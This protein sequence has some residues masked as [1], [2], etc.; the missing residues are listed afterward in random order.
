MTRVVLL[1]PY[2]LA[3]Y[4]GVQEQALAMSRE[5]VRRGYDVELVAP[6]AHGEVAARTPARLRDAGASVSIP[7]NGSRAAL[8]LAPTAS[9]RARRAV[10]TD[11]GTVVHL[12]EPFAPVVGWSTLL[13]HRTP[14]VGTLHRAGEGPA[15]RWTRPIL[16]RLARGLDVIAAVS[17]AAARTMGGAA[18]LHPEI[19]FNGFETDRYREVARVVSPTPTILVVGRLEE[20]KGTRVA[21]EAVAAHNRTGAPP[22]RLVVLGEGPLGA[23]LRA[24]FG[25]DP[26]IWFLGAASD[27]V[28]RAW[29][30]RASVVVAPALGRESFGLVLLEAMAAETPVVASDIAGYR[31]AAQ[32]HAILAR[33]GDSSDLARA[34]AEALEAGPAR[35]AGARAHA[36]AWSMRRLMD[37]YEELYE[38]ARERFGARR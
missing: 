32:G 25:A 31:E 20:R 8:A 3:A 10:G 37:R 23:S 13:T 16:R 34:I 15:T 29:L 33:P 11:P 19:L 30:R 24:G 28:K 38:R 18:G 12:H 22:W 26:H 36:E 4:G 6:D 9:R 1:C 35:V 5:L 7:A 14:S 17:P 21:L 2:S 27:E